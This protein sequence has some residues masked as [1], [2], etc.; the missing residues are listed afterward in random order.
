MASC[1]GLR[2]VWNPAP[3]HLSGYMPGSAVG[4]TQEQAFRK[5]KIHRPN[6][7]A[8]DKGPKLRP[9]SL[10]MKLAREGAG[11]KGAVPGERCGCG[12]Y[13][14]A[15]REWSRFDSPT[16]AA[17]LPQVTQFETEAPSTRWKWI[18]T[19]SSIANNS[20]PHLHGPMK[21]PVLTHTQ[22]YF[23]LQMSTFLGA[24]TSQEFMDFLESLLFRDL[25]W[26]KRMSKWHCHSKGNKAGWGGG[27]QRGNG[28]YYENSSFYLRC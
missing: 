10:R 9:R 22:P 11:F 5:S 26:E 8:M 17:S 19:D 1:P 12:P 4:R 18:I 28:S 21:L 13:L 23:I 27:E 24:T 25:S 2:M 14:A 6:A 3:A 15:C 16:Q 20:S 7:K